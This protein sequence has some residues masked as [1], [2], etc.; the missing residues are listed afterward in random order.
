MPDRPVRQMR[1]PR[2]V[3]CTIALGVLVAAM[4]GA[5]VSSAAPPIIPPDAPA[6]YRFDPSRFDTKTAA[7][8]PLALRFAEQAG[9]VN[10]EFH[11]IFDAVLAASVA[12]AVPHTVCLLELDAVHDEQA[13]NGFRITALQAVLV[14]ESARDHRAF[15]SALGTILSH[16]RGE[17]AAPDEGGGE[18]EGGEAKAPG[19][20]LFDLPGGRRAA[21][22]RRP[23]W[24]AWQT[25]EW[26]SLPDSFIVG[27]GRGSLEKW[28]AAQ[29][30]PAP[31]DLLTQ[32]RAAGAK[33]A[34]GPPF[35]EIWIDLDA[36]RRSMPEVLA[37]GR[38]QRM[39]TTWRL[40]NA[41][42]WMF[43]GRWANEFLVAD[44][45]W[46]RRSDPLDTVA[47]RS[48]TL[49]RWP[50]ELTLPRPEGKYCVVIPIDL[51]ASFDRVLGAWR[52]TL[53]ED[54]L[55]AFDEQ[56]RQYRLRKRQTYDALWSAFVPCVVL[57]NDPPPAVPVPGATTVYFELK[58]ARQAAATQR[59]LE[60]LLAQFITA[61]DPQVLGESV[62][63]KESEGNYYWLQ[64][65]ASGT[66]RVP[67]WGWAG[68]YL[69]GGWGPSVIEHN[70]RKIGRK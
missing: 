7:F 10:P 37:Q 40:D 33:R 62:V 20:E 68:P 42:N 50:R 67:S 24:A 32:H 14:L 59:R 28:A 22:F 45:T 56:V 21:R 36:L 6:F 34:A 49:D 2:S 1:E 55:P 54:E 27:L 18:E 44:L 15:L 58:D 23:Q 63:R 35:L 60:S 8:L 51:A 13:K 39:L 64:L 29:G 52:D 38:P 11:P 53:R 26:A 31:H 69:I 17:G 4:G 47:S 57:S 41:R 25:V 3:R 61:D 30:A 12:G 66:L 5:A 46:Q 16:Y 43:H 19:Q 9:L 70:R 48:L 65:E